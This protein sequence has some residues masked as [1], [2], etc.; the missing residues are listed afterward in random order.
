MDYKEVT[1]EEFETLYE[2]IDRQEENTLYASDFGSHYEV[3][4][5]S[6]EYA[7]FK[8]EDDREAKRS[9]SERY[10]SCLLTEQINLFEVI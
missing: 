10:P 6:E 1:N 9:I 5:F 8:F 2:H 3:M 7:T 4:D